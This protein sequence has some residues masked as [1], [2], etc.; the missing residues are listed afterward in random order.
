MLT[1][2]HLKNFKA[3]RDTGAVK[4]SPVTMLLGT[5]SS[6]KSSLIQSLLLL[7]QTALSP[8]R[9][10][11]LNLGGDEV[12]DLFDFG[13]F[14]TVL[15]R[16][17]NPRQFEIAFSFE[18]PLTER[19]TQGAFRCS[20]GKT[21]SGSVA[22][23][24]L[25]LATEDHALRVIRREKGAFSLLLNEEGQPRGKSRDY[26][27]ER[28][29]AL[30]PA[31]L[32]LLA[33]EGSRTQDL[34]LGIRRE[35]ESLRYLGPLRRKPERDYVWNKSSPG[36]IGSDGGKTMDALFASNFLRDPE[37]AQ[38]IRGVS[39]WLKRMGV[40]DGIE[41]RQVGR[42][43]R[44][45][46]V[47]KQGQSESN[48]RDVGIGVSQVLPVLTLAHFAPAGSTI[49]L[50]EPEIHLHPLAQSVLAELFVEASR[51]RNIQFIVETHSE[52]LFRRMQTLIA[53]SKTS[54]RDCSMYF[55]EPGALG[56]ELHT[57]ELDEFGAVANWPKHFFGDSV[58]EARAQAMA[59]AQRMRGAA[60]G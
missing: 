17:A 22:V 32:A 14:D 4:L 47:V 35:L 20:Y 45:E 27:P 3:W 36:D 29:I 38:V 28:S 53:Q 25:H 1:T 24:E 11:H 34:S 18:R 21:S 8:D 9:S 39:D 58:G 55:V 19:V 6:G 60:R 40:A 54:T 16:H 13:D 46:L 15:Y 44:Y 41:A 10:I 48:L 49:I 50:E 26:A 56:A 2:L 23:Q 59:R 43:T 52:H 37:Q 12:N 42:S 57:L 5:N 51:K 31:A 33:E 30:P 7:K